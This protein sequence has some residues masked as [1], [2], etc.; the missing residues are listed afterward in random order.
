MAGMERYPR[1]SNDR[2]SLDH[3]IQSKYVTSEAMPG[4]ETGSQ[5]RIRSNTCEDAA[6]EG[7]GEYLRIGVKSL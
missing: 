3:P 4:Y 5:A 6:H 2:Q 7:D 1:Y